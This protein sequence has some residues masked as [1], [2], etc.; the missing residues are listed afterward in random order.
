L[1]LLPR[2]RG[3]VPIQNE[4]DGVGLDGWTADG[5][6]LY[7]AA[8]GCADERQQVG[9]EDGCGSLPACGPLLPTTE[10]P[11]TEFSAV[12]CGKCVPLRTDWIAERQLRTPANGSP[13]LLCW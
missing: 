7:T 9:G 5:R 13:Y 11:I 12:T 1:T 10:G 6:L 2:A 8:G 4:T 3:L